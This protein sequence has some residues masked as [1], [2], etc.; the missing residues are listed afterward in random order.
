[1]LICKLQNAF[2]VTLFLRFG[3][4]A[5]EKKAR[6]SERRRAEKKRQPGS[7]SDLDGFLSF[8]K[9]KSVDDLNSLAYYLTTSVLADQSAKGGPCLNLAVGLWADQCEP[10]DDSYKEVVCESYEAAL[11]LVDFKANPD[12]VRVEVNSWV[13]KMTKGLITNILSP[14]SVT[15]RTRRIFASALYI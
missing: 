4:A 13:E 15:N 11:E 10:L 12:K 7:G 3:V 1:M 8:L 9:S 5:S 6:S 2:C 14:N